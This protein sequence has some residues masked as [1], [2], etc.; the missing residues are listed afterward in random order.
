M[1][2][3]EAAHDEDMPDR[4]AHA[5]I[6]AIVETQIAEDLTSVVDAM[7]R[8]QAQGLDRHEALHAVGSVLA[9]HMWELLRADEQP[10]D[11]NEAY[12]AALDQLSAESWRSEY[13]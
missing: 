6:H 1:A 8:L 7:T 13:E 3:I 9:R 2:L 4:L 5:A 10:A 11:P 12:Y